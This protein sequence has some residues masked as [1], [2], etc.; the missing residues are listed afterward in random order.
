MT[1]RPLA[2]AIA[3]YILCYKCVPYHQSKSIATPLVQVQS[4]SPL[5]TAYY[6]LTAAASVHRAIINA[7]NHR[8]L[9][10]DKF[11]V[12]RIDLNLLSQQ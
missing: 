7:F 9:F 12:S 4:V 5:T 3:R 6:S 1:S 10:L 8:D 11:V 2:I